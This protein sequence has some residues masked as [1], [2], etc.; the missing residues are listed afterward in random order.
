MGR[1]VDCFLFWWVVRLGLWG[2]G[3]GWFSFCKRETQAEG[4]DVFGWMD[5][6]IGWTDG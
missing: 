6:W 5:G 1:G 3:D 2:R 4:I